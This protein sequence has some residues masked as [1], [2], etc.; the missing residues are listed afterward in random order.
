MARSYRH[1]TQNATARGKA[2]LGWAP[3]L[4]CQCSADITEDGNL[5]PP[6]LPHLLTWNKNNNS[7]HFRAVRRPSTVVMKTSTSVE[8][9]E[10]R[11]LESGLKLNAG[12]SFRNRAPHLTA[13]DGPCRALVT[14]QAD[15]RAHLFQERKHVRPVPGLGPKGG[16]G[17]QARLTPVHQP[18]WAPR[19]P[20]NQHRNSCT[21]ASNSS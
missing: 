15:S 16:Q 19:F 6:G 7:V 3:R 4:H 9:Q 5:T 21:W 8:E 11:N 2:L 13:P 14:T 10:I 20:V 17:G 18:F 12:L 1:T